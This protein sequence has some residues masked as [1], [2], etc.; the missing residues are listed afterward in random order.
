MTL[1]WLVL[2]FSLFLTPSECSLVW[3]AY[4]ICMKCVRW[5]LVSFIR[6]NSY[7]NQHPQYRIYMFISSANLNPCWIFQ[8]ICKIGT[9]IDVT[10]SDNAIFGRRAALLFVSLYIC[11]SRC[12]PYACGCASSS[13]YI[14]VEIEM[15]CTIH[16]KSC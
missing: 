5:P 15:H 11:I 2:P 4:F 12:V 14:C 13:I 6:L 10:V 16:A 3:F 7:H 1:F 9:L 8:L